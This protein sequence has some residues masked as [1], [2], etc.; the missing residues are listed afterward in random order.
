MKIFL[1]SINPQLNPT[2][3]QLYS[4]SPDIMKIFSLY[5]FISLIEFLIFGLTLFSNNNMPQNN[6][7]FI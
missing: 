7:L 2:L 4:L 5:V 6:K 3:K 1:F